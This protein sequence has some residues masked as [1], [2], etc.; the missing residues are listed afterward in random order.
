M[1][2][3]GIGDSLSLVGNRQ[4]GEALLLFPATC[5]LMIMYARLYAPFSVFGYLIE[6]S[7]GFNSVTIFSSSCGVS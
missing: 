3:A 7:S 1:Q 2:A 4:Q 5:Y 6:S